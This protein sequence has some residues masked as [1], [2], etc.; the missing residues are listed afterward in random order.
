M[1]G[2]STFRKAIGVSGWDVEGIQ[3]P[4]PIFQIIDGLGEPICEIRWQIPKRPPQS[5]A[6]TLLPLLQVESFQGLFNRLMGREAC[7]FMVPSVRAELSLR[8]IGLRLMQPIP[9]TVHA[10]IV[11]AFRMAS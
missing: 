3:N 7:P 2:G 9:G 4:K 1:I 10:S 8:Q 5:M 11:G 6:P